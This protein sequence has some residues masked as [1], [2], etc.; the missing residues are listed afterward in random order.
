M[1]SLRHQSPHPLSLLRCNGGAGFVHSISMPLG[2]EESQTFPFSSLSVNHSFEQWV[3][4]FSKAE[5][6]MLGPHIAIVGLRLGKASEDE[7]VKGRKST[8][9]WKLEREKES[10]CWKG[11]RERRTPSK[12]Q[13]YFVVWDSC[14]SW[15]IQASSLCHSVSVNGR[16]VYIVV[17][18]LAV[19]CSRPI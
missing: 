11:K 2:M 17:S 15:E 12:K 19:I 18:L 10:E 7:K 4:L 9:R 8:D 16:V 13:A 3:L 1:L 6:T 5:H 14:V